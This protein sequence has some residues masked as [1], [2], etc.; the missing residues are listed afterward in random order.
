MHRLVYG[1]NAATAGYEETCALYEYTRNAIIELHDKYTR[2]SPPQPAPVMDARKL[3][4]LVDRGL[5]EIC[6]YAFDTKIEKKKMRS[7][8][9]ST[10]NVINQAVSKILT[11]PAEPMQPAHG[12]DGEIAEAIK[13]AKDWLKIYGGNDDADTKWLETLIA[14]ATRA[15][16]PGVGVEEINDIVTR[17]EAYAF[18]N[19]SGAPQWERA[20]L[21][22]LLGELRPAL[23]KIIDGKEGE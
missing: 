5:D 16:T 7:L 3:V 23:N 12:G 21:Q 4:E 14:A 6:A 18:D 1:H 20:E 15:V 9:R 11:S 10:C 19:K 17:W 22:R 13:D 8:I 2:P